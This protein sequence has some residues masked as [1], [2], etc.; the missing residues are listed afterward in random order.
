MQADA[1]D[2]LALLHHPLAVFLAVRR[3]PAAALDDVH[4]VEEEID[5]GLVEIVDAGVADGGE[6]AA[7]V[8]VAGEER[9]LDE[10]RVADRIGDLL[11]LGDA[12]PPSTGP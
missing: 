1:H 10:R 7:E 12:L 11:A 2:D 9:G 8:R 3:P 5:L 4:V 6:D